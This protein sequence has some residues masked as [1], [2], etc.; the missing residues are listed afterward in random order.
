MRKIFTFINKLLTLC[1]SYLKFL[2]ERPKSNVV[3]RGLFIPVFW[4]RSFKVN[5]YRK[6]QV[7]GFQIEVIKRGSEEDG[8]KTSNEL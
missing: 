7:R 2:N 5:V 4:R 6:K 8:K 1:N 3:N